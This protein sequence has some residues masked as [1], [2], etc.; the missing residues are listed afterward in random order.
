MQSFPQ[1]RKG[2]AENLATAFCSTSASFLSEE[3]I[4]GIKAGTLFFFAVLIAAL[5]A[6]YIFPTLIIL[7]R[8]IIG[9]I[10]GQIAHYLI[11]KRKGL[12]DYL[13]KTGLTYGGMAV[14]WWISYI[15]LGLETFLSVIP[16]IFGPLVGEGVYSTVPQMVSQGIANPEHTIAP[17]VR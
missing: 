3:K 5:F 16:I 4:D 13:L 7:Y 1:K 15:I 2:L 6:Y 12:G 17:D 9:G 10:V 14:G 8:I 11:Y